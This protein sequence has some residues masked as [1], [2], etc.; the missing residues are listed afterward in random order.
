VP[1]PPPDAEPEDWLDQ[2]AADD[3]EEEQDPPQEELVGG[4][5]DDNHSH[6]SRPAKKRPSD[7]GC[8]G[9]ASKRPRERASGPPGHEDW[10]FEKQWDYLLSVGWT[11]KIVRQGERYGNVGIDRALE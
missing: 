8:D 11:E 7:E 5:D 9:R 10:T 3:D 1:P 2:Q 6:P 4:D